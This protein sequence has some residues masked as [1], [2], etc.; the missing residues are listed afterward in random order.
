M[1]THMYAYSYAFAC[2]CMS[3]CDALAKDNL[4]SKVAFSK[5][6]SKVLNTK[7]LRSK[8]AFSKSPSEY[9]ATL[10]AEVVMRIN[11][12]HHRMIKELP[13]N[14]C[15][16]SHSKRAMVG[17]SSTSFLAFFVE[18]EEAAAVPFFAPDCLF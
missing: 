7:P 12:S 2:I 8:V 15:T 10:V 18:E 13:W 5:S 4:R 17:S 3:A 14:Q 1:Y 16:A 9:C 6:P 11:Q